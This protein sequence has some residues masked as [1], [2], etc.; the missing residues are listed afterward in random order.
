MKFY[1]IF[2][3]L[4][5]S[6]L[7]QKVTAQDISK[8]KVQN[9]LNQT[10]DIESFEAFLE[11]VMLTQ[12]VE[13]VSLALINDGQLAYHCTKGYADKENSVK[14]DANTIFEGASLSKP[15][16]AFFFMQAVED[17]MI[18]LDTPLYQYYPL[19]DLMYDIRFKKLTARMILSH[20]SGLPNW[21]PK[22]EKL[23]LKFDPGMSFEYSGEGYQYLADV[24]K[25]LYDTDY[26]GLE[27]LFQRK[28]A[29]PLGLEVTKFVQDEQNISQKAKPYKAGIRIEGEPLV[30][31]FG[32]AYSVHSESIDFSHWLIAVMNQ[33]GLS[34]DGY[35]MLFESNVVL[36][37]DAP[38]RQQGVTDWTLGFAKAVLPFGTF[39]AHGGN[40]PGYSSLFAINRDQKWGF[41]MFC[42]EDQSDLPLQTILFLHSD[43]N[44]D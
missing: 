29:I 21:R 25:H 33:E 22:D 17:G 7:Y 42:N 11:D 31:E 34:K 15:L 16:F 30:E 38:Q 18:D 40:N 41:I 20:T 5:F 43:Q 12:N 32:A 1:E 36:P 10:I 44:K 39:Y 2:A 6:M 37:D 13:G 26:K 14:V 28:V 4:I 9:L 3:L 35:E 24:L 8:L 27:E 19:E 23:K